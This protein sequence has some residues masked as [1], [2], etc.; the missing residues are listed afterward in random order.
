M[1]I[2]QGCLDLLGILTPSQFNIFNCISMTFQ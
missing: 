1:G 2:L